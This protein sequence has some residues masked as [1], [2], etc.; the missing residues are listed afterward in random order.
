LSLSKRRAPSS[1]NN[2]PTDGA[3]RSPSTSKQFPVLIGGGSWSASLIRRGYAVCE[4]P[5]SVDQVTNL[6]PLY[7]DCDF[8]TMGQRAW[9]AQLV[10][11][12]LHT[13]PEIDKARIAMTGYS[14]GG[15]MATIAAAFDDRIAAVIAGSTGVGGVLPWRLSGE[16][17]MGEGIEST[18]R[19][20]PLWF[21]P[22][23]RF[24]AGR[25]D[26]LP[27]DANLLVAAIAPRAILM[28]YG[29]NDEVSNVWANEQCYFSALKVYTALGAPDRVSV[30]RVPGF[31]GAN[32]IEASLDWLD[33]Q[34]GRS[35][36]AWRNDLLFPWSFDE[37]KRKSGT[38]VPPVSGN[39]NHGQDARATT[40]KAITWLLG[41]TPPKY[42]PPAGGRGFAGR[43]GPTSTATKPIAN[44]GQ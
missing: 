12:Y 6:P 9:T 38:G 8:A 10:V 13:V 36:K 15:K 41:E 29:H 35:K 42:T 24:F 4:F 5:S 43:G 34:F 20:F 32:D 14:R 39:A 16:R 30:L 18:T 37:W 27:I 31:H 26:R 19:M 28:E 33:L 22:Q 17:G 40:I 3:R 25:E 2:S 44:P 11:D 21:A 23:A 7:P 1:E